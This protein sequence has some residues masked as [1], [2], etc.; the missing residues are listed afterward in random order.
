ME[1]EHQKQDEGPHLDVG[2]KD[3]EKFLER[4]ELR[5]IHTDFL[6]RISLLVISVLGF[7]TALA[8]DQALKLLFQEFFQNLNTVTQKVLYAV[9]LT[10]VASLFSVWLGRIFL[11]HRKKKL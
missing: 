11:K 8:W 5:N 6:E 9:A 10:V 1:Q 4:Y 3:L 7:I 2:I